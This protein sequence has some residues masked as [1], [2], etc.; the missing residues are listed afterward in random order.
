MTSTLSAKEQSL[1]KIFSDDYVFTIPS[2]QRPYSWGIDQA[3]ELLEDLLDYMRVD[4]GKLDEMAPYFLGSIVLIKRETVSETTVVDGQQRLTTLTLLLSAIRANVAD[5]DVQAGITKCIYE[6]GSMVFGTEA[7]Y[8]LS[9][10][11][12]DRDFFRE[13][14][15]HGDGIEK[16]AGLNNKLPDAQERLRENAQLYMAALAKL[17]QAILIRL[18]QFI[19]TR[20]YLV[21]VATPDLDSAYRIFGVLNSRGLDL[22]ATDILKAEIIGAIDPA[23]RDAYTAK[24]ED[25]EEDLGRD[26]F[27]DLFSHIR[28]VYRKAK[29]KG[30][31]LKEFRDHVGPS[32]PIAFID[33][34]LEPMAQAFREITDADYSSQ[35]HAESINQCL[36]WLN[37]IEF[38]DWLPPALAFFSRHRNEP[39]A[40]LQFFNDLERLAY[41]M[42]VRRS[43]VNER[44]ERFAALTK[45]IEGAVDLMGASSPLQLSRV[46]QYAVYTALSGPLYE[47]YSSRALAV[48]LLRLDGLVSGGGATYDYDTITVEHVMPQQPRPESCWLE[49][50]PSPEDR[51]LWVHRLGNLAL[52]TRKKNSAANNY[53][54]DK[55]KTAYFTKGGVSPFVLTTQVLQH[56]EWTLKVLEEREAQLLEALEGHWRLQDRQSPRSSAMNAMAAHT[57][58]GESPVYEIKSQKQNLT[59]S[60]READGNFIV[61][62]G[63]QARAGWT[64]QYHSYQALK[65]QLMDDGSL[66]PADGGIL[67]FSKNVSFNSPSATSAVIFGRPDN[68][69]TS[70]VVKATGQTY[71]EREEGAPAGLSLV[72]EEDDQDAAV[73]RHDLFR[74]FWAQLI[75]RSLPHTQLFANRS[76]TSDHWLSLGVGRT[77]FSLCVSI[78]QTRT[79][80][81]CYIRLPNDDGERSNQAFEALRSQRQAIEGAFGEALEWQPLPDRS[82]SR[83]CLDMPGGWKLPEAEWPQLQDKLIDA[84]TRLDRALRDPIQKL[85]QR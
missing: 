69:R 77:G 50:V 61:L 5:T 58:S 85:G 79:R 2:Y 84:I 16:L 31:L 38:K 56:S 4:G 8:R 64:G 28:M 37:R 13:Y 9:L 6:Q 52:L 22:S 59:A 76:A 43:G 45:A 47:T 19:V 72:G 70:W 35:K 39:E 32:D 17:D 33:T 78:T 62:A 67:Q 29:P 82:G 20:C 63:S 73:N 10:R 71:A 26:A 36:R 80:A 51:L 14:V 40:M 25:L 11:E 46:E 53:D 65:Q 7:R 21:T 44:I 57:A 68:G 48:I 27:G 30:T 24:W 12:R 23:K 3:R 66:I 83:I 60:A 15:Q 81:E 18:V 49:W 55:K 74:L 1:S 42:L 34:V 54:F 75:E 41:S